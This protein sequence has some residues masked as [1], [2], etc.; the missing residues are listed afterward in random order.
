MSLEMFF[1]FVDRRSLS[2]VNPRLLTTMTQARFLLPQLAQLI[3]G[4]AR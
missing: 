1:V 2:A 3:F 4:L